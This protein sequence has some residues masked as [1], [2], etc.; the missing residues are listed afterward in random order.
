[1]KKS[2]LIVSLLGL[3]V[4]PQIGMETVIIL[5]IGVIIGNILTISMG[6]TQ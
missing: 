6:A 1:M 2:I 4:G 3:I 5:G